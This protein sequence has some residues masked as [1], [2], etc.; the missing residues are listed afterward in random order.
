MFAQPAS[1]SEVEIDRSSQIHSLLVYTGYRGLIENNM[2]LLEDASRIPC[3]VKNQMRWGSWIFER[4]VIRCRKNSSVLTNGINAD[5]SPFYA[6]IP[7]NAV[8]VSQKSCTHT[9]TNENSVRRA[10]SFVETLLAYT[11]TSNYGLYT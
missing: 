5:D 10:L 4:R 2:L 1:S 6:A 7:L 11:H 3:I 9:S 8:H